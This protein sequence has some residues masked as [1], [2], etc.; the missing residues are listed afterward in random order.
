MHPC[1]HLFMW[2]IFWGFFVICDFINNKKSTPTMMAISTFYVF[3]QLWVKY[4]IA[5][6]FI[7]ECYLWI[8][9]IINSISFMHFY[10][11]YFLLMRITHTWSL[12]NHFRYTLYS[13]VTWIT[14]VRQ[15]PA[16]IKIFRLVFFCVK[17]TCMSKYE[18]I[19]QTIHTPKGSTRILFFC[20]LWKLYIKINVCVTAP[21][22]DG[23][24]M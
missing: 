23:L 4:Y 15:L 5:K 11:F 18:P 12:F 19:C 20:Y 10:E 21:E 22:W 14:V 17:R 6:K 1:V 3:C 2:R 13:S 8:K 7:F 9:L 24:G 16:A